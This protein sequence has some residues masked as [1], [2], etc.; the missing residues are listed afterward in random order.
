MSVTGG[1]TASV[2]CWST[3]S[4]VVVVGGSVLV[5]VVGSVGP[6][7]ATG[8]DCRALSSRSAA[9]A[10]TTPPTAANAIANATSTR[11][12]NAFLTMRR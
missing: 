7:V 1:S 8:S 4:V 5:V 2:G 9:P 12:G 11:I 6:V 3:G 10:A